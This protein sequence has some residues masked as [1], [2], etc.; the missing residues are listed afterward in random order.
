MNMMMKVIKRFNRVMTIW[1]NKNN[2]LI[3]NNGNRMNKN[4]RMIKIRNKQMKCNILK[5]KE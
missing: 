5:N 4:R 2:K 1:I 3:K